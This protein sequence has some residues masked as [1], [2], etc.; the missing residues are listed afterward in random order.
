MAGTKTDLK[1][2]VKHLDNTSKVYGMEIRAENTN[3]MANNN[4]EGATNDTTVGG[5]GLETVSMFK[6]LGAIVTDEGCG[7]E[8]LLYIAQAMAAL[9]KLKT[10]WKAKNI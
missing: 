7:L 3:I 2:L 1:T 8:I 10:T 4:I 6:Y 5:Q 9:A